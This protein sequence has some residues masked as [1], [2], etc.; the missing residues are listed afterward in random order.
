VVTC[1]GKPCAIIQPITSEDLR[2]LDWR[3]VAKW[4]LLKGWE[5]ENDSL[6]DYL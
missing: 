4:R 5:R 6:Y 1:R 2:N 3:G